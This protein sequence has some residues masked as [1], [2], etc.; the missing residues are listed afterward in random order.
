[1]GSQLEKFIASCTEQF[2]GVWLSTSSLDKDKGC[3]S[4]CEQPDSGASGGDVQSRVIGYYES[5]AHDSEC[6]GMP[7]DKIPVE[8]LTHLYFSFGYISP[9]DFKII[10]MDNQ[11]E[12]LFSDLTDLKKKNSALKTVVAL[13]GWTFNDNGTAYQPVFSNMVSS[14]SNRAKF[15]SNL[16]SF[17]LENAFDGVD[18]DWVCIYAVIAPI[19]NNEHFTRNTRAHQ[20]EVVTKK[21]VLISPLS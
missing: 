1:M 4:G 17:L 19:Y 18:F 16:L 20:T 8:G 21:T 12:S 5:W 2:I 15:I 14:A 7:F 11:K 10:P 13:G 3:Q 6:R 9:N